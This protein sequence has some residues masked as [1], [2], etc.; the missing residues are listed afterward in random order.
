[1]METMT[2]NTSVMKIMKLNGKPENVAKWRK[3]IKSV[4]A[5]KDLN[6]TLD[7]GFDTE[8]CARED[9]TGRDG[10]KKKAVHAN[11]KG[12]IIVKLSIKNTNLRTKLENL[13][14]AEWPTPKMWKM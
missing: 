12:Y 11:K 1:M 14:S 10:A 8:L 5:I 3:D 7:E 4:L 2:D 13:T 6:E 9:G